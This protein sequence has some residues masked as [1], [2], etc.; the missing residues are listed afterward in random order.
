M[1]VGTKSGRALEPPGNAVN[2]FLDTRRLLLVLGVLLVEV[3]VFAAGLSTPL[4]ASV[5][6]SIENQTGT[7]FASVPTASAPQLFTFIFT[8]N[9]P[10]ALV[11]M[12]P[13]LGAVVFVSS[14]YVT[15]LAAQVGALAY[16]YPGQFGAVL[17]LFPYSFVEFSAY[18]VAVGAGVM[19]I[20][21]WRRGRLGRELR[22]LVLEMAAVPLLLFVAAA[23]E[24]T[25]KFFPLAGF[26]LWLPTGLA[27]AA[28]AIYARRRRA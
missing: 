7:Q 23:M 19:L 2:E 5:R 22:V 13:I 18:A 28:L 20:V 15:G 27:V 4:S 3:G 24:T 1:S 9:L 6:H 8:H 17:L 10:F 26:A 11:E 16:G 12:I 14:I 25:T 21:S